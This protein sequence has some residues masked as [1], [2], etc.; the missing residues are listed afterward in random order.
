MFLPSARLLSHYRVGVVARSEHD[1]EETEAGGGWEARHVEIDVGEVEIGEDREAGRHSR[2]KEEAYLRNRALIDVV[3]ERVEASLQARDDRIVDSV[4]SRLRLSAAA[5]AQ[6][7]AAELWH[8]EDIAARR[9]PPVRCCQMR[10]PAG[11]H[12]AAATL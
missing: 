5:I 9:R 8:A 12:R 6:P 3:L 4:A 10:R 1:E 7:T 2:A 11:T